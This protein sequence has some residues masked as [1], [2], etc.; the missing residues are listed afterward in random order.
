MLFSDNKKD[1]YDSQSL[2][3]EGLASEYGSL[4]G[5]SI[6]SQIIGGHKVLATPAVR[7]IA[8]ENNVGITIAILYL[9]D[10]SSYLLEFHHDI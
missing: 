8:M 2:L 4:Y 1:V 3:Q 7:R 10:I 5:Q 6:P 9:K